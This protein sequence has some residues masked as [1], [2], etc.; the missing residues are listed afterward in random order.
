LRACEYLVV[1]SGVI[2]V[3][4][5][6]V[7]QRLD[8]AYPRHQAFQQSQ[9]FMP[10]GMI[11]R[12]SF[13]HSIQSNRTPGR[14][15]QRQKGHNCCAK[16]GFPVE[17]YEPL[18]RVEY[19]FGHVLFV[20]FPAYTQKMSKLAQITFKVMYVAMSCSCGESFCAMGQAWWNS[21]DTISMQETFSAGCLCFFCRI[22]PESLRCAG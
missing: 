5:K 20:G 12:G 15:E 10:L 4:I 22:R 1:Y 2:A 16:M 3:S 18:K 11:Y 6:V 9:K 7:P 19:M 14:I 8:F 21:G 13:Y 17:Y